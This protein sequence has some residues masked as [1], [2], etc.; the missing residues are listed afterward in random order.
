[1]DLAAKKLSPGFAH[2]NIAKQADLSL[3]LLQTPKTGFVAR[4]EVQLFS[5]N[6]GLL[7]SCYNTN[8]NRH[9]LAILDRMAGTKSK[10]ITKLKKLNEKKSALEI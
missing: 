9:I 2:N 5:C 6:H 8:L 10:R 1:M 4:V 7:K 3:A